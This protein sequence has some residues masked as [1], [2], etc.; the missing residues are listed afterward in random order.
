[1]QAQ[2]SAWDLGSMVHSMVR[3]VLRTLGQTVL[4]DH[5]GTPHNSM[6]VQAK[7]RAAWG[8]RGWEEIRVC[9]R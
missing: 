6:H 9:E 5:L 3:N 8:Y 1:M 7:L 4:G 2:Y